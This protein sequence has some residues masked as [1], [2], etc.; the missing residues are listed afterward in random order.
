MFCIKCGKQMENG[1]TFCTSCGNQAEPV[2]SSAQSAHGQGPPSN[3]K[4]DKRSIG[5]NILSFILPL[6]GL[7]LFLGHRK[8]MPIRAKSIGI[9]TLVGA[10][11]DIMLV[12]IF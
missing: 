3:S 8:K 10:V 1:A 11:I 12:F 7:F 4:E 6:V 5:L 9:S 2:A